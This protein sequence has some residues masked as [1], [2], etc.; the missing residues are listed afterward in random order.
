MATNSQPTEV[1]H[2]GIPASPGI[3]MGPVHVIARG[4]SAP[5]VF[6]IGL[7]EVPHEQER[8]R[9][10][11]DLTKKQL[12]ELQSRLEHI[13]G[14]AHGDIFEA[15]IMMLE[16][17]AVLDRVASAIA[18]RCQNAEYAFDA[19]MQTFLEGMRRIPDPYF[20]ERT[21]DIEDVSKRVLRNFQADS[22]PRPLG[23]DESH[24]LIAY[25]LSPSDTASMD[26]R[27]LLGFALSLI[28]I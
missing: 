7:S 26:R 3:A 1:V 28:H 2:E 8:F 12:A 14:D 9:V 17:S 16:D 25:D 24:I 20:R 27:H 4:F 5:E 11:V 13:A 23:P 19:V 15:H 21:A 22:D 6:E 18:S 10:A